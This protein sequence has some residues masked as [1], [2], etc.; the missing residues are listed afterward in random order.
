MF[1]GDVLFHRSIGRSDL[2]GGSEATLGDSIRNKLYSLPAE[3]S[4]YPGH[5]PVTT[6]GDEMR[7]N[8]FYRV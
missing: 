4:A 3:T 7:E 6:I 5:G 1:V 2:P 8:P